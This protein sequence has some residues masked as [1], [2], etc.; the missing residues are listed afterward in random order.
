MQ[1]GVGETAWPPVGEAWWLYPVAVK[2]P[3]VASI[4]MVALLLLV[5]AP[6]HPSIHFPPM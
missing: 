1:G 3:M 5:I 6:G 4:P 2:L